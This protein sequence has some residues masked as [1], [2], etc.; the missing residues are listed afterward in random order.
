VSDWQDLYRRFGRLSREWVVHEHPGVDRQLFRAAVLS[1]RSD[2]DV[3]R[4]LAS[5]GVPLPRIWKE[6]REINRLMDFDPRGRHP[7]DPCEDV[8]QAAL[9]MM[10]HGI[11]TSS[12]AH[13]Q[14]YRGQRDARWAVVPSF[15]RVGDEA[16]AESLA[17]VR[18]LAGA[19]VAERPELSADQALALIQHYS[20]ELAAPTWLL[21]MTWDPAVALLFASL[22]GAGGDIGVVT[23]VVR[24][25]WEGFSAAGRNR[26]GEIRVVE[27][28][29]VLRIERQRALFL[30][31]SHPDL[32]EQYVAH[33]VWFRQVEGLVFEDP[34][35][36]WPVTRQSCFPDADPTLELVRRLVPA[37]SGPPLAPPSDAAERLA[38]DDYLAIAL[39]WCEEDGVDLEAPSRDVLGAVC[40]VHADLQAERRDV[41]ADLR[42][43]HRLR[44]AMDV[45]VR[46]Q[47]EG[48]PLDVES[49]L[50]LTLS[51]SMSD[52]ERDVLG[53]LVAAATPGPSVLDA[54]VE[55]LADLP[56]SLARLVAF[57]ART[58][59]DER[60][61]DDIAAALGDPLFR[62][63]DL[64][65]GS[66]GRAIG[67]LAADVGEAVRLLLVD[68]SSSTGWLGQLVRAVLD[69]RDR[70][71]FAEGWVE[72]PPE[73]S[74]VVVYYGATSI[75]EL[76]EALVH[77]DVLQF[78]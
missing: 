61:D 71:E 55:T 47:A 68:S 3:E 25:E 10:P 65:G 14:L 51:R 52:A 76:P 27:V 34:D 31:T 37:P 8:Y 36:A 7:D 77:V 67:A 49:A 69:E 26:L 45:V 54:I 39:S 5:F 56:S 18:R 63:F 50:R 60:V 42:S 40:R 12:P 73:R 59:T 57:G 30:D 9:T 75:D 1:P 48:R 15:F 11:W 16:R 4:E 78:V 41:S 19:L 74:I 24:R 66:D 44:Q 38:A 70:V 17:R 64:R 23:M 58:A 6:A 2:A 13:E 72:L 43:L 46:H 33:S 20:A 53:R 21:D 62:V 35:A 32:L 22:G 28:P 29:A